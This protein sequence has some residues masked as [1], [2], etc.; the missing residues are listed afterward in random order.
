MLMLDNLTFVIDFF[1]MN[2]YSV[3]IK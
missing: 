3:T 2:W 1:F